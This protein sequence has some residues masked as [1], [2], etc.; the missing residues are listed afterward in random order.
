MKKAL[1]LSVFLFALIFVTA[2]GD[3][4]VPTECEQVGSHQLEYN[5]DREFHW[6]ECT[7]EGCEYRTEAVAHSGGT[8]TCQSMKKCQTCNAIY[9][10]VGEHTLEYIAGTDTHSGRCTTI[11]CDYVERENPHS[12]GKSTCEESAACEFCG[13]P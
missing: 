6:Q 11:G 8:A 12:G 5:S 10:T 13:A 4:R 3:P 1:F 7:R 2:C 9:G